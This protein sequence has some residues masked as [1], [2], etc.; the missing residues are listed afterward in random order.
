MASSAFQ[1]QMLRW[2]LGATFLLGIHTYERKKVEVNLGRE[3][4]RAT[5][6]AGRS[7]G[8]SAGNSGPVLTIRVPHPAK[9]ARPSPPFTLSHHHPRKDIT[10]TRW[11]PGAGRSHGGWQAGHLLSMLPGL[12]STSCRE[13]GAGVCPPPS[14]HW[15]TVKPMASG[16]RYVILSHRS[17]ESN[18]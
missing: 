5:M 13:L 17:Q 10:P 3:R 6:Q 1:N 4:S 14:A 7:P 12:G 16:M 2:N 18:I 15:H 9:R 8:H 11:L